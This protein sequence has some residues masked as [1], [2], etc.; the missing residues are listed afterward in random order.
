VADASPTTPPFALPD[1]Q[2]VQ[3]AVVEKAQAYLGT[4]HSYRQ[5]VRHQRQAIVYD[6]RQP[7]VPRRGGEPL[8]GLA[9]STV[10][11]WLSWLGGL[12]HT[13]HAA[14][15]LIRQKAPASALHREPWALSPRKYRSPQR[16][17]T[18]Q[19]AMQLLAANRLM[20][21]LFGSE[22]FPQFATRQG[23]S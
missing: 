20:L 8:I 5:V 12:S 15:D 3:P 1:K 7:E 19:Q 4:D 23:W 11:R 21:R 2:F 9:P 17:E 6:D 13:L 14:C 22:I 16:Q 18:L 10:W